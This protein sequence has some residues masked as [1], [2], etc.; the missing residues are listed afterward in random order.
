MELG[1]ELDVILDLPPTE[2]CPLQVAKQPK[3]PSES[4]GRRGWSDADNKESNVCFYD[5]FKLFELSRL[6]AQKQAMEKHTS[7]IARNEYITV[8]GNIV[9]GVGI[10]GIGKT[11]MLKLIAKHVRTSAPYE[12]PAIIFFIFIR[13]IDFRKRYSVLRFLTCSMLSAWRYRLESDQKL[14]QRLNNLENVFIFIDSLDEARGV[15]FKNAAPK[16]SLYDEETPDMIF[17]N[18]FSGHLLPKAKKF[19]VSRPQTYYELNLASMPKFTVNVLGFSR[20]SVNEICLKLCSNRDTA[21]KVH[22]T[23][24]SNPSLSSLS[25]IPMFC[26]LIIR[27][28][29]TNN[30]SASHMFWTTD[31]FVHSLEEIVRSEKFQ[32]DVSSIFRLSSLALEGFIK[33]KLTFD[34]DDFVEAQVSQDSIDCFMKTDIQREGTI[35]LKILDGDKIFFFSHLLW[36]EFLSAFNLLYNSSYAQ[37][38]ELSQ[39]FTEYR[40]FSVVNFIFGLTKTSVERS[41]HRVFKCKENDDLQLKRNALKLFLKNFIST[42][43]QK[44]PGSFPSITD[45]VNLSCLS[46]ELGYDES[47][48]AEEMMMICSW[49]YES[50]DKDFAKIAADAFPEEIC[51]NGS[52]LPSD[53]MAINYLLS[54]T[55]NSLSLC[56]G[57]F[58]LSDSVVFI[59]DGLLQFVKNFQQTNHQVFF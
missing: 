20:E 52:I 43:T 23:I 51:L 56:F 26:K 6:H 42:C 9:G 4:F 34:K 55:S 14:L 18:I 25:V 30:P 13:D 33:N 49:L 57:T 1:R 24:L 45:V 44:S 5:M 37:F 36:Q 32:S 35:D 48:S 41:L 7:E 40:W 15:H 38:I 17:M 54:H 22:N 53:V 3:Q 19:L 46:K 12:N 39:Y 58:F 28:V 59:G 47:P 21:M 29:I 50:N 31:I 16:M 10:A 8:N 2:L 27:H 11:T